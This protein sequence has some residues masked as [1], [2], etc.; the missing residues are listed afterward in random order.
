MRAVHQNA[1]PDHP[2]I[3]FETGLPELVRQD[4]DR[5]RAAFEIGAREGAAD[6]G[7]RTQHVEAL[8]RHELAPQ[9]LG[10]MRSREGEGLQ[11]GS[12]DRGERAARAWKA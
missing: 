6:Q 7:N 10:L 9:V 11:A 5:R 4:A 8:A 1:P 2:T 3:P 12:A